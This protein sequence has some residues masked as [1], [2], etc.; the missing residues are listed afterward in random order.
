MENEEL[1]KRQDLEH[2]NEIFKNRPPNLWNEPESLE[3]EHFL[4]CSANPFIVY[5]DGRVHELNQF[6]E[7]LGLVLLSHAKD[8]WKNLV[9]ETIRVFVDLNERGEES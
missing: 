2:K 9:D 8:K 1:K 3:K 5:K 7:K 4:R 6:V